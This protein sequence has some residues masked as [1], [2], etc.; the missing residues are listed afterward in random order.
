[1]DSALEMEVAAT[2]RRTFQHLLTDAHSGNAVVNAG[3]RLLLIIIVVVFVVVVVVVVFVVVVA[4]IADVLSHY[5]LL[6]S[7]A[8]C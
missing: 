8:F 3:I 6:S 2:F 7:N 4:V 1:M 5:V